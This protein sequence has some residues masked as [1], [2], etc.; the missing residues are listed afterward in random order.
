MDINE[1]KDGIKNK[2]WYYYYNFDGIEVNKKKK[3]DKT[4]GI[5]NWNRIKP[6]MIDV[7]SMINSPYVLDIGC[8]MGLYDY[9]MTKLGA[10]VLAIDYNTDNIEFYKRYVIENKKEKWETEV[11]NI[12][13]TKKP[14]ISDSINIVTMFCVLYHLRPMHDFVF[15]NLEIN[16]PNHQYIVIQGNIPRIKKYNQQEAGVS[17]MKDILKKYGYSVFKIYEL[18]DY[19][20]PVV[21]GRNEKFK[22]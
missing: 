1:I 5:Y 14:I 22:K 3:K 11:R 10:K 18:E 13:I 20:K 2:H 15:N 4:L 6:I 19:Q 16:I 17:G 9:E 21:I 12:D 8:N 7:F